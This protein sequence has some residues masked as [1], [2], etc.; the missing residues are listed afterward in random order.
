[1]NFSKTANFIISAVFIGIF[2][3]LIYRLKIDFYAIGEIS[4]LQFFFLFALSILTI[5]TNGSKLRNIV[6]VFGLRLNAREWFGL[7]SLNTTLN[8][9]FF[10]AGSLAT[11]NYL[12]RKYDFPYMSFVGSQGAD[13]LILLLSN[14]IMGAIACEY[15]IFIQGN[16]LQWMVAS[17]IALAVALILLMQ[18]EFR[19]GSTESRLADALRRVR[20]SLVGIFKNRRLFFILYGHNATLILLN[21]FRFYVCCWVLQLDVPFTHC[22]LFNTAMT[23]LSAVPLLQSDIGGREILVGLLSEAIGSGFNTGLTATAVDRI[24]LLLWAF[25]CAVGC[26]MIFAP[27]HQSHKI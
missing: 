6:S 20:D 15:I 7:S 23:F 19:G 16:D 5:A 27:F 11:S 9:V 24:F 8:N 18:W 1:M 26:K 14:A 3:F 4:F 22:L 12:K 2:I 25:L 17:Y 21:S 10:K 13:Q